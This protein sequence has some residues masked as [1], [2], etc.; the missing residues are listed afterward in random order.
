MKIL[1]FGLDYHNYTRSL[2]REME[3]QGGDVVYVDIQPRSLFFK[4]LRTV[5]R[6]LYERYLQIHH[7]RAV[8]RAAGRNYDKVI[9]L[10]AH[11]MDE[12]RLARLR[13]SL[14]RAQFTLYN[15]DS[16]SNHDY[17]RQAPI[18]DRVL[19]FD[20]RDAAAYGYGYL[21]LF[22]D[23][24][25]QGLRRDRAD[26]RTVSMIGNL[27]MPQRYRAVEA[28]RTYSNLHDINFLQYLKISPVSYAKMRGAGLRPQGVKLRSISTPSLN[29][30]TERSA[31]VFD[32]ANHE[33]SGQTMRMMENLCSGKKIITNNRWV[34]EEPFYSPDRIHVFDDMNFSGVEEFLRVP[35]ADTEARFSEYHIQNF[36]R[37]LLGIDDG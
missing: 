26:P 10:Q 9:F 25:M 8:R 27:V 16:I 30:I 13:N 4:S 14:P 6:A 20:S 11:Q 12:N 21:P 29:D 5:A 32:F 17:R 2:I 34:R 15:W 24:P 3:A 31:A 19:T 37:R 33:Q 36:T 23:R 1:F 7:E 28:F 18:F 22:C 35:I